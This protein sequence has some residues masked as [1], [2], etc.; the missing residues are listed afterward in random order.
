METSQ[1]DIVLTEGAANP[2]FV[3]E[4]QI[5]KSLGD[6]LK[7]IFDFDPRS[8]MEAIQHLK[9]FDI[10][11]TKV[12]IVEKLD[13]FIW[14]KFG[15]NLVKNEFKKAGFEN[16]DKGIRVVNF[17]R[18]Y[19]EKTRY[20][21]NEDEIVSTKYSY[22]DT[23]IE[24]IRGFAQACDDDL[25]ELSLL[26][27]RLR[28]ANEKLSS[29][30]VSNVLEYLVFVKDKPEIEEQANIFVDSDRYT[31]TLYKWLLE[32]S[33]ML[34]DNPRAE[35]IASVFSK[36]EGIKKLNFSY[37]DSR[38]VN[39]IYALS[40]M[41]ENQFNQI[42]SEAN[43]DLA[44]KFFE[45]LKSN[46]ENYS[47]SME[48][49]GDYLVA[50]SDPILFDTIPELLKLD[51][52]S[53]VNAID[54]RVILNG[55]AATLER[56]P[57]LRKMHDDGIKIAEFM[58]GVSVDSYKN[59]VDYCKKVCENY[60]YLRMVAVEA[61]SD[62]LDVDEESRR[63]FVDAVHGSH[64]YGLNNSAYIANRIEAGRNSADWNEW[65]AVEG[66]KNGTLKSPIG[67]DVN[68]AILLLAS[69][70]RP[71]DEYIKDYKVTD[72]FKEDYLTLYKN[73]LAIQ[74]EYALRVNLLND[75]FFNA[76]QKTTIVEGF[77]IGLK[78]SGIKSD[79][80]EQVLEILSQ[81]LSRQKVF[82]EEIKKSFI[83]AYG[84]PLSEE[85]VIKINR[86]REESKEE[87]YN[88]LISDRKAYW[89][90]NTKLLLP[91]YGAGWEVPNF[92]RFRSLVQNPETNHILRMVPIDT[93]KQLSKL[94]G[95]K[96]QNLYYTNFNSITWLKDNLEGN[97]MY[98]RFFRKIL[99]EKPTVFNSV[100]G[101]FRDI[102]K[103]SCEKILSK[104]IYEERLLNAMTDFKNVTPTLIKYFVLEDNKDKRELFRHQVEAFRKNVNSN[105]PILPLGKGYVQDF[106]AEM[107]CL[108]FPGTNLQ[109]VKSELLLIDD[110][111]DHLKDLTIRNEG[112]HG[113]IASTEKVAVLRNEQKPVDDGV[114][115]LLKII[116]ANDELVESST[117]G[118]DLDR[119]SQLWT[120][121]LVDAGSTSQKE[122]FEEHL[123][124]VVGCARI[125][126]GD[127][128]STFTESMFGDTSQ[129][130][131]KNNLLV[132]ARELFGIY[133]KDNSADVIETVLRANPNKASSLI[134]ILTPDKV[135]Q[136]NRFVTP[137]LNSEEAKQDFR[138][139]I[140]K[141]ESGPI[142]IETLADLLSFMTERTLHSGP[143]GLRKMV[144]AE[145][146]KIVLRD[147]EGSDIDPASIIEGHV[148]KNA[149]SYFAKTSAGICTAHDV[150]LYKRPDHFHIN[151][152]NSSG[153][154]V[155]N[156]QGYMT[157]HN[158][159]PALI[160]RGFNPS[161]SIYSSSNS[162]VLCDQMVDIVKQIAADNNIEQVYI[163]EQDDWHRLTNRYDAA[164]Y[165]SQRYY[166]PE[167]E[168]M[169]KFAI[170][171]NTPE[172]S[173]Y[174]KI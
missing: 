22:S 61:C 135:S 14:D 79:S 88:A 108:T 62:M 9:D 67:S 114:I 69:G 59:S 96:E 76:E 58:T 49:V 118:S 86:F 83:E 42:T 32:T 105:K 75:E 7:K 13:N 106:I 74:P 168:V 85:F 82:S 112:Y 8:G 173:K 73:V 104:P 109:E 116:F 24:I 60:V 99:N 28:I 31:S 170:R 84:F 103:D 98:C 2:E 39:P 71:I 145:V 37:P 34:A 171:G 52:K 172:V 100:V 120:R 161:A 162:D 149:A 97:D 44:V 30:E 4:P 77:I 122:L 68:V 15:Q 129:I 154:V 56:M 115:N 80:F 51:G 101:V 1:Q 159:K 127:K 130:E 48:S 89:R 152:T 107:I 93:L 141:L 146:G 139:I 17:L 18:N 38:Y 36:F 102:P 35:T 72:Q 113:K 46:M 65:R 50:A 174:Y 20:T 43:V 70:K 136:L 21:G 27:A 144:A 3:S 16:P 25:S 12:E 11:K 163:P 142:E 151:L 63:L 164:D 137:A 166:K 123:D 132:K 160:F 26:E 119:A 6:R 157:R 125:T 33:K 92:D 90:D 95:L 10:K 64:F 47:P 94:I 126:L 128:I 148:S 138:D 19:C 40:N 124:E 111:C 87:K 78:D 131:S 150:E 140:A 57:I 156:I 66:W 147:K 155:G 81:E 54:L 117:E 121:L 158:G 133:Y 5:S 167:N 134:K 153:I 169:M 41:E 23:D 143:A 53:D 91:I 29:S 55:A 165:F 45:S 110:Y